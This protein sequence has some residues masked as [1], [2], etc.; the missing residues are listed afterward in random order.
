MPSI[1]CLVPDWY[2][3]DEWYRFDVVV[4]EKLDYMEM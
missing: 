2:I 1:F 4:G 3:E